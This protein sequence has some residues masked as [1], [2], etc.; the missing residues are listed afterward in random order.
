MYAGAFSERYF[1]GFAIA[2][3]GIVGTAFV[4]V[5]DSQTGKYVE[6]ITVPFGFGSDFDPD[7]PYYMDTAKISYHPD[8]ND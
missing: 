8:G 1:V 4:Y 6:E 7:S 2:D 3:A 5:F